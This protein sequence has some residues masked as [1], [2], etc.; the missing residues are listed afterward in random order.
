MIQRKTH[1]A[2]VIENESY[3]QKLHNFTIE[4]LRN[5]QVSV[6]GLIE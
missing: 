4:I 3:L 2:T 5:I 1:F 6:E